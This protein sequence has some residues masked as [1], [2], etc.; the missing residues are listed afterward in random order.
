VG[1]P[2][3]SQS[4]YDPASF[5][6]LTADNR[7]AR[8]GDA[9]TIQVIESAVASANADTGTG[10]RNNIG[11]DL[12]VSHPRSRSATASVGMNGEFDGGGQTQRAGRL[13]AQLTVTVKEVLPNGDLL[14]A[15][16]QT[17]TINDER[18]RIG[19]TGRVRPQDVSDT[20]VVVSSRVADADI[21]YIGE[22]HLADRQKPAWWRQL[23]DWLGF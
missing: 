14:V 4:L 6:P 15:G 17:L 23:V 13:V 2:A 7:A 21:T 12:A 11:V 9:I 18:Q 5:R 1:A 20:N 19:I 22:G 8:V 16:E 3:R 10:R